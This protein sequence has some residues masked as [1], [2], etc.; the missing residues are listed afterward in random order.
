[1]IVWAGSPTVTRTWTG[2]WPAAPPELTSMS[3]TE[4]L[5]GNDTWVTG[6]APAAGADATGRTPVSEICPMEC[7]GAG[8]VAPLLNRWTRITA[9]TTRTLDPTTPIGSLER[10]CSGGGGGMDGRDDEY[11]AAT[12]SAIAADTGSMAAAS[13]HGRPADSSDGGEGG[14]AGV[15]SIGSG[16]KRAATSTT[17]PSATARRPRSNDRWS[18]TAHPRGRSLRD[19]HRAVARS[20]AGR[21]PDERDQTG[22]QHERNGA[23][24][25]R[26]ERIE[27]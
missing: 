21:V 13:V 4:V 9:S 7:V 20:R 19:V 26:L 1:M 16:A 6:T 14:W 11:G 27:Q 22:E 25:E 3:T 24:V 5:A 2:A 23:L 18:G 10:W 17:S 15:A 12:P 8:T